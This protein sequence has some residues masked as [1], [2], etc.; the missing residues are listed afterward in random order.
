LCNSI[1]LH[2]SLLGSSCYGDHSLTPCKDMAKLNIEMSVS[3]LANHLIPSEWFALIKFDTD[4]RH[5]SQSRPNIRKRRQAKIFHSRTN[6][7]E[8]KPSTSFSLRQ[9]YEHG[10]Q[11]H[12]YNRSFKLRRTARRHPRDLSTERGTSLRWRFGERLPHREY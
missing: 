10:P 7:I 2:V 11:E 1:L 5:D 9:R 3:T 4:G 6:T 12:R 8:I